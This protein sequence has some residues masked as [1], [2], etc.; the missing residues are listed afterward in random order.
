M[1]GSTLGERRGSEYIGDGRR[2]PHNMGD[3][4]VENVENPIMLL[5]NFRNCY[6]GGV[7][8]ISSL[9]QANLGVPSAPS[10]WS[11]LWH[12]PILLDT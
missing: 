5:R 9:C 8:I 6:W 2:I 4:T 7:W 1:F 12:F 11:N 10:I 3:E